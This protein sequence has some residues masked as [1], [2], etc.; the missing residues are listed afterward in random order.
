VLCLHRLVDLGERHRG[1]QLLEG[2]LSLTV[3]IEQ[4]GDE[5]LRVG[6]AFDDAPDRQPKEGRLEQTDGKD[7]L[8]IGRH[9]D[10]P[11]LAQHP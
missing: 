10:Q 8:R 2:E 1:D 11:Q 9:S 4:V 6:V 7:R 5:C 3:Q